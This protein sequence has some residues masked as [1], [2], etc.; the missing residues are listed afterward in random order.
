MTNHKGGLDLEFVHR[1]GWVSS[2]ML[3]NKLLRRERRAA[4]AKFTSCQNK[5]STDFLGLV[6]IPKRD[7]LPLWHLDGK[8]KHTKM[9]TWPQNGRPR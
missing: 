5:K 9:F 7:R 4:F 8:E 6:C 3:T 2:P 1:E